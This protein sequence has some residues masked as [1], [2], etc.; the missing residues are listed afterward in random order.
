MSLY[1]K[2]EIQKLLRKVILTEELI[3]YLAKELV[4]DEQEALMSSRCFL[5]SNIHATS[6]RKASVDITTEH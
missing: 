6:A 2:E 4:K 3:D 1:K 5:V